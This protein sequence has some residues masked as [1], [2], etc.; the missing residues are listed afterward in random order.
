MLIPFKIIYVII[1]LV[2]I[3]LTI[4]QLYIIAMVPG[5]TNIV[6]NGVINNMST[7]VESVDVAPGS[8]ISMYNKYSPDTYKYITIELDLNKRLMDSGLFGTR[9]PTYIDLDAVRR[10]EVD[11]KTHDWLSMSKRYTIDGVVTHLTLVEQFRSFLAIFFDRSIG[12]VDISNSYDESP[13][14]VQLD[15]DKIR[16]HLSQ[17][18]DYDRSEPLRFETTGALN[19]NGAKP[20]DPD[21]IGSH[22]MS[23]RQ[24][25][26]VLEA[27][28]SIGVSDERS[29][30]DIVDD[31]YVLALRDGDS[32]IGET[33]VVDKDGLP[34]FQVKE[35]IR[36]RFIQRTEEDEMDQG[37]TSD[38]RQYTFGLDEY[39]PK[40]DSIT[41]GTVF[42]RSANSQYFRYNDLTA[43]LIKSSI[44]QNVGQLVITDANDNVLYTVYGKMYHNDILNINQITPFDTTLTYYSQYIRVQF[45]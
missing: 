6:D 22:L 7:I 34:G 36:I 29:R 12:M 2:C 11:L 13:S 30:I 45:L 16:Y 21:C 41:D 19:P 14:L 38:Q 27:F 25:A 18:C 26:Q 10:F 40:T 23:V 1:I 17:T 32:I 42:V 43:T 44:E 15:D 5:N 20:V 9:D 39:A 31:Q 8:F 24:M 28:G 4:R 37:T 35:T 33:T 3:V